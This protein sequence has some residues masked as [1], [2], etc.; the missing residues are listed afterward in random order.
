VIRIFEIRTHLIIDK[1]WWINHCVLFICINVFNALFQHKTWILNIFLE[2]S[3][4]NISNILSKFANCLLYLIF[5]KISGKV[6]HKF[7]FLPKISN[8]RFHFIQFVLRNFFWHLIICHLRFKYYAVKHDI[9]NL[10]WLHW[11]SGITVI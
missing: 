6:P 3:L 5:V 8:S 10:F 4:T 2:A 7:W 11:I 1:S 9:G